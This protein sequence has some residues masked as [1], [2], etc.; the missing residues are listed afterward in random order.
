MGPVTDTD[1]FGNR[2]IARHPVALTVLL[3]IAWMFP[4]L[5]GR[6]PWKPDEAYSFGLVFHMLQ[7]GDWVVPTLAG[8]PFMEKP[9]LFY[10]TAALFARGFE[11]L[12]PLHDAARLASAFYLGLAFVFIGLAGK[13]LYDRDKGQEG[14]T[15]CITAL[16]LLGCV[17]L[18]ER[19]HF[20]ITDLALLAG[21]VIALYGLALA[22]RRTTLGG[23]WLG[24]GVGI[25]FMS[26]GLLA[27]GVFG[28]ACLLLPAMFPAWR[29]SQYV[30]TLVIAAVVALPWLTV[31]PG[32][33]YLR[34]PELFHDWIWVN[35]F[36]RYFGLNDLG[37]K[38]RPGYYFGVLPWFAFPA[39][40]IALWALW[41]RRADIRST[42]A[43]HMPLTVALVCLAVLS[44][45]SDARELYAMP[46]LPCLALLAI[47]GLPLL[48][49]GAANALWSF[50]LIVFVFFALVG[51]FYWVALDLSFPARLHA[52]LIRLRP[53]YVPDWQALKF[54]L[55]AGF[56][57]A[58]L[59]FLP[60]IPRTPNRPLIAWSG[61]LALLWGLAAVLFIPWIDS[62]NT[63]RSMMVE[64]RAALPANYRCISSVNFGEPQRAMLQYFGGGIVTYR[65]NVPD[66]KRDC[67][68][69]LVQG[70]YNNMPPVEPRWKMFWQG[71]RPGDGKELYRLYRAE[72]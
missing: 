51:W 18:L 16:A 15:G 50:S 49:R 14:G 8:E 62:A 43:L 55:A 39:W 31:W 72:P 2:L 17:G 45:S 67:D 24:M 20:M 68:V 71:T 56:T 3:C 41:L 29:S 58:W 34:S 60:H 38:S 26:K 27:P 9:P 47:P 61:S 25:G 63:Y 28:I 64:L 44:V 69:L 4:G 53:A 7:T 10:I 65:Q 57:I 54:V 30:R 6:D 36:G 1:R 33:L 42:P 35:N 5:I 12:L 13:E 32:A 70:V 23:V 40:P 19:G 48:R 37:P 11:W 21:C 59:W 22:P 46:I 66:R 52:H